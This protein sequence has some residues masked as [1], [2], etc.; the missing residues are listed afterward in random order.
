MAIVGASASGKTTIANLLMRFY[1]V[2]FGEILLDG[3]DI[4]EYDLQSL[5][6]Y[7]SLSMKQP[8]LLNVSILE[9]VL[10]GNRAAKNS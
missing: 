7:M 5:R 3:V 8:H 2:T 1:D 4:K 6:Q 10:Y 9:N